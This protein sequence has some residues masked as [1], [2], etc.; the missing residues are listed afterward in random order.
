MAPARATWQLANSGNS[1]TGDLTVSQGMLVPVVD[2]APR[3]HVRSDHPQRHRAALGLKNN[4]NYASQS[5]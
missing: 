4:I 2:G 3:E 5:P 1:F